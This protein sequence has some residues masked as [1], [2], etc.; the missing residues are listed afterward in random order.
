MKTEMKMKMK[1]RMKMGM[2]LNNINN[3]DFPFL[4]YRLLRTY[5]RVKLC[6]EHESGISFF[7]LFLCFNGQK[8]YKN[9]CEAKN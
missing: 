9:T 4:F 8:S 7:I 6:I 3:A 1:M 2:K 5:F